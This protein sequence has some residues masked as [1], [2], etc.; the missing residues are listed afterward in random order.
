MSRY[1]E[2]HEEIIRNHNNA[3]RET[4]PFYNCIPF[5]N[6]PTLNRFIPGIIPGTALL[7]S[8]R[9][10]VGKSKWIRGKYLR[11]IKQFNDTYK[12]FKVNVYFNSLEE[13]NKFVLAN[14]I[15]N[16]FANHKNDHSLTFDKIFSTGEHN[17]LDRITLQLINQNWERFEKEYDFIKF[18]FKTRDIHDIYRN[19]KDD[20]H[21]QG[22]IIDNKFVFDNPTTINVMI[23]DHIGLLSGEE[24]T[25]KTLRKYSNEYCMDLKNNYNMTILNVQQQSLYNSTSRRYQDLEPS[26]EKL[27]EDRLTIQDHE[28]FIGLFNPM[29]FNVKTYEGYNVD[30]FDSHLRG[31]VIKK[32]RRGANNK[33]I[34]YYLNFNTES[35]EEV[36]Y[37]DTQNYQSFIGRKGLSKETI[38]FESTIEKDEVPF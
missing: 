10:G 12:S 5:E 19:I 31:L 7:M 17:V 35:W 6:S 1:K 2:I 23:T 4:N 21:S 26:E 25:K 28:I 36:P 30:L 9:S 34:V 32:N 33:R 29:A 22:K 16:Y 8:A 27:G 20:L 11:S 14:S 18:N 38:P 37:A 3:T 13:S 15:I 24:D